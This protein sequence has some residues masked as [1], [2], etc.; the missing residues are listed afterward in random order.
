[1]PGHHVGARLLHVPLELDPGR[2]EDATRRLGELRAD[3]VAGNE[4]DAMGDGCDDIDTVAK[5]GCGTV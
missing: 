3:S 1:V 4:G 5:T 2:L